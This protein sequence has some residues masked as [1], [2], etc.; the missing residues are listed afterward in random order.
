MPAPDT[1]APATVMAPGAGVAEAGEIGTSPGGRL[2][3]DAFLH[4]RRTMSGVG[5]VV[6]LGLFCF[7]GPLLYHTNQV[8]VNLNI[9]NDPPGPGTR[10]APTSTASTSSAG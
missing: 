8:T 9:I 1:T 3:L 4:N 2:S 5:I 6:L 10:S 7:I